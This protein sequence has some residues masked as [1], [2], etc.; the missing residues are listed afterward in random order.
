MMVQVRGQYITLDEALTSTVMKHLGSSEVE[1][2][3]GFVAVEEALKELAIWGIEGDFDFLD[4]VIVDGEQF[5]VMGLIYEAQDR[6]GKAEERAERYE[7][8]FCA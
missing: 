7:L 8:A 3:E 5:D 6:L 1:I 2:G 4:T